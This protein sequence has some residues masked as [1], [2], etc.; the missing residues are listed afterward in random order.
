MS[1][2][3]RE[4][5]FPKK[6]KDIFKPS[7]YKVYYGG[8][9]SGKS[10]SAAKALILMAIEGQKRILCTRE[11]QNS[12]KD[13][14][15]TLLSDQIEAMGLSREFRVT[16]K[17]ITCIPTGSEFI[18]KG[19][20]GNVQSVKS[21]EGVDI[22]WVE[23]A[24]TVSK[25]SWEVLIP[26]I[27]KPGS[28][29]WV[30]MNPDQADD[31]TYVRFISNTPPDTIIELVNYYD[32]N[33][34]PEELRKEAEYL[35]RVDHDAYMNVWEGQCTMRSDAQVLNGKWRIDRF[36][37]DTFGN[38]IAGPRFLPDGPYYG[39]DWGF[40]K[41]PTTLVR[42]WIWENKL[43]IDYEAF[44]VG[45]DIID[46]PELFNKVP[47]ANRRKIRADCARPE[48]ISHMRRKGFDIEGAP[49]WSGSVE[50]GVAYLR[51]F[52]EIII[53]ERCKHAIEEARLWS[54]KE[55]P[56]TGDILP[57]LVDK[58]N[59]IWDAVR[60]ALSPMIQAGRGGMDYG[61]WL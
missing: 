58:H 54:Y 21:T 10:W 13:S 22:C 18:F 34:L 53:H 26:T 38:K 61:S 55:D 42:C 37:M 59:H 20:K 27:R 9:G 48:T 45:C 52:E 39:A 43:W 11:F 49:K 4:I 30:T 56:L 51:S 40:A 31:P 3:S 5:S 41:D 6:F 7:R 29:I 57:K 19:L 16:D 8:R 36:D 2:K 12:L 23:E 14:V 33:N 28:E 47:D 25:S 60:Y 1:G 15:L 24:Q 44:A 17:K 32:N 50:D 35:K 46:T